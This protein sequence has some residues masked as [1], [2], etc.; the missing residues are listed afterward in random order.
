M[1][2]EFICSIVLPVATFHLGFIIHDKLSLVSHTYWSYLLSLTK[3]IPLQAKCTNVNSSLRQ[4]VTSNSGS[5]SRHRGL[6]IPLLVLE[7]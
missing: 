2:V 3:I 6:E 1:Y 4:T 5:I 7:R